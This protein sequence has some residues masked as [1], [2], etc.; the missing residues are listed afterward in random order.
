[1]IKNKIY[2]CWMF[3]VLL[4]GVRLAEAKPNEFGKYSKSKY[5]NQVV[6]VNWYDDIGLKRLQ[7][8][9]YRQDFNQLAH[10]FAPQ[11]FPSFCGI[12]SA[13]M[14][15]NA[16]RVPTGTAP[17][18]PELAFQLP[19]VWGGE[20]KDFHFYTQETFFTER[21]E[22]IK[23]RKVIAL[24]NITPQNENDASAFQP[25]VTLAELQKL[26]VAHDA[27]VTMQYATQPEKDGSKLFRENL[28]RVLQEPNAFVIA[29]FHGKA[30]GMNSGGHI[31]PIGAYDAK[32]DS[33]LLLDVAST[34][35]PWVWINVRDF[36][37]AMHTKDGDKYRGYL[38]ISD[39]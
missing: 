3:I 9:Q 33:I 31:S 16:L 13:T 14:V 1:M 15:L 27:T 26:L 2:L 18:N 23:S 17:A 34:K 24:Q 37:L 25:G 12:A 28:R 4:F 22:Q 19:K 32:T 39:T 38:I 8:S 10:F 6:I 7:N 36:Y 11:I 5:S 21:T 35:R 30:L 20:K 29:N